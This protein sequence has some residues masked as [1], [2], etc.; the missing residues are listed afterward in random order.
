LGRPVCRF[1]TTGKCSFRNRKGKGCIS[2]L[3]KQSFQSKDGHA[4]SNPTGC[5]IAGFPME[6]EDKSI[7]YVGIAQGEW[8]K[9]RELCRKGLPLMKAGRKLHY[10]TWDGRN[11]QTGLQIYFAL[12]P[13]YES[14][15]LGK[16]RLYQSG[17][18]AYPKTCTWKPE[19]AAKLIDQA[20]QR[21]ADQWGCREMLLCPLLGGGEEELPAEI[22]AAY[23]YQHR[24]FD[25]VFIKLP[26]EG[27][28]FA[29]Q[30]LW[31]LRPYLPR[32]RQAAIDN[33]ESNNGRRIREELYS[34]FGLVTMQT[35]K[36]QPGAVCLDLRNQ[37]PRQEKLSK[38]VKI[39]EGGHTEELKCVNRDRIW[40]FLDTMVKNGYN[41]EVN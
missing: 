4:A 40:N 2:L 17:K 18:E 26:E 19:T 33:G 38:T 6:K 39:P 25:R 12:I 10:L 22:V 5:R 36:P 27:E 31:L 15:I 21:A 11:I 34:E 8:G 9:P 29:E 23:L 16:Y 3:R 7:F 13:Q 32:I 1:V 14:G 28:Y 30:A 20:F 37:G 35:T 24:P 41:T